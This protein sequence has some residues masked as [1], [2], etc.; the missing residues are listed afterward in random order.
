MPRLVANTAS[1]LSGNGVRVLW[2]V[3]SSRRAGGHV[4]R[5]R[6]GLRLPFPDINAR[7][8]AIQAWLDQGFGR[9]QQPVKQEATFQAVEVPDREKIDKRLAELEAKYG[10]KALGSG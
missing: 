4:D 6:R 8:K 10:A 7:T 1:V 5:P 3:S 2:S 9:P